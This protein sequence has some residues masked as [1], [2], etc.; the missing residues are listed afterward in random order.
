MGNIDE[1]TIEENG[2]KRTILIPGASDMDSHQLEDI[3]EWQ[4]EK[5]KKELRKPRPQRKHS[6]EEVGQALKDY[7]EFRKRQREGTRKYF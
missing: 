6:K 3:I 5:T 7:N 1:I 4:T 2:R